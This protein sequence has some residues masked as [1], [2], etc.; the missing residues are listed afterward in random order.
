M[1]ERA[2]T[3]TN[4]R[5]PTWRRRLPCWWLAALLVAGLAM[6]AEAVTP[7]K[8]I[9]A[10]AEL[11]EDTLLDVGI[12]ILDPGLPADDESALEDKGVFAEIRIRSR[13]HRA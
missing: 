8:A 5:S 12:Q 1:V 13:R 7:T 3:M 4:Q 2:M 10:T 6:P 9:Q 11:P